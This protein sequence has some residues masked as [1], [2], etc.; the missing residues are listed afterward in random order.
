MSIFLPYI[1]HVRK[2]TD[3]RHKGR[4][5]CGCINIHILC[6]AYAYLCNDTP[7]IVRFWR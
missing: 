3:I 4:M 1:V 5:P 2:V 7:V 6:S